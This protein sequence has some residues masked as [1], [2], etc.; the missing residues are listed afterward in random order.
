MSIIK[1]IPSCNS[2]YTVKDNTYTFKNA[3]GKCNGDSDPEYNHNGDKLWDYKERN[4]VKSNLL[5]EGTYKFTADVN[6]Q[7]EEF[8]QAEWYSIFQ[9]HNGVEGSQP[10]SLLAVCKKF[11]H[12]GPRNTFV[13]ATDKFSL[14]AEIS[15]IENFINVDYYIDNIYLASSRQYDTNSPFIKF[16]LYRMNEYCPATQIYENVSVV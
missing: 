2:T 3:R 10:P 4:E 7:A 16:G 11:W 13:V 12:I 8:P 15:I 6:I 9:L 14:L 5:P 1:F